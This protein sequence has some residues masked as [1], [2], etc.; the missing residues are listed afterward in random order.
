MLLE[1][2]ELGKGEVFADVAPTMFTDAASL[3]MPYTVVSVM[4]LEVY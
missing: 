1:L 2:T 4:P 3:L